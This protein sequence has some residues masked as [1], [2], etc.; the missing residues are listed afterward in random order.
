MRN[1]FESI[2]NSCLFLVVN[3]DMTDGFSVGILI[4]FSSTQIW[5]GDLRVRKDLRSKRWNLIQ[6]TRS[7]SFPTQDNIE[8]TEGKNKEK[9]AGMGR[10]ITE[11]G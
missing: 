10:P 5:S 9:A 1:F 2:I 3:T 4:F 7:F 8:I 6:K 11:I